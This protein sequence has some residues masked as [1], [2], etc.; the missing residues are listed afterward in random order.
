MLVAV[1]T[2]DALIE[3]TTRF[4]EEVLK[5]RVNR[6]KSGVFRP[7]KTKFLGFTFVGTTGAPRAHK[8]SLKRLKDK[9]RVLFRRARGT[10]LKSTILKVSQ[11][12]MG[13]RAYF[14]ADTRVEIYRKIDTHI[15]RHLRKAIWIA[16]K[17]PKTREAALI[18]RGL[19]PER[20]WKSSVNG[21]GAWWNAGA[22]H[23][24]HAFN[25]SYF[26]RLGLYSQELGC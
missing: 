5:L 23:K 17:R 26:R 8:T 9:L 11:L 20:A 15:K 12:L 10:T 18:K 22:L 19:D 7:S 2:S 1:D 16:W 24:L 4:I 6:S 21:R 25:N 3:N 13:W 14:A